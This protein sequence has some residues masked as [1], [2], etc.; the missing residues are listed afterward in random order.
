MTMLGRVR[1]LGALVAA[2][3]AVGCLGGGPRGTW[4]TVSEDA[5][6]DAPRAEV[7]APPPDAPVT[8]DAAPPPKDVA[9][10]DA[11]A[12]VPVPLDGP[13]SDVAP[14]DRCGATD[15]GSAVGAGVARGSTAGRAT[16][17]D[18]AGCGQEMG[19]PRG[20]T[21]APEAVF[22]WVAPVSGR[23]TFDTAGSSYDTLLYVRL[24]ACDG[25]DL[26][27][28]DDVNATGGDTS[29]RVSF[30]LTRGEAVSIVVDGYGANAGD[31]VLNIASDT[32]VPP[33]AGPVCSTGM[34]LCA[35]R[36]VDT[37]SDVA[38]CGGCGVAC[39]GGARCASGRCEAPRPLRWTVFVYGH[40][41]HNLS[42]S[43][44]ADLEEMASSSLRGAVQLVVLSDWNGGG[45]V[46]SSE[47]LS[48]WSTFMPA[49]TLGAGNRWPTGT[50][51]LR[52]PGDRQRIEL[53]RR[54]VER[55]LDDP[56]V[57]STA[58]TEA[59]TRYPADRYGVILWDHGGSWEG[60]FG[61]D[62]GDGTVAAPTGMSGD[63]VATALREG[64]RRAGLTAERPFE[65]VAFDTCLMATAEV[66]HAFRDVARVYM[67]EAELDFG[68]G[69]DYVPTLTW[70]ASN[71]G[72]AVQ[73]FAR[74]EMRTWGL[75]H[76]GA[77]ASDALFRSKVALDLAQLDAFEGA[78]RSFSDQLL[79]GGMMSTE[80][81]A[82]EFY[83]ARPTY[84]AN[85]GG[86]NNPSNGDLRDLGQI[87]RGVASSSFA[88][89]ALRTSARGASD[90][91]ARMVIASDAGTYRSM[92]G[93]TGLHVAA[94]TGVQYGAP[95]ESL[96]RRSASGW[97][98]ATRW[99]EV[100]AATRPGASFGP[101]IT[102][103]LVNGVAPTADRL[104]RVDFFARG[105]V[106]EAEVHL[107]R[108]DPSFVGTGGRWIA[109]GPVMQSIIEADR[110]YSASWGGR[111]FALTTG[112][113][114]PQPVTVAWYLKAFEPSTRA[115]AGMMS[116]PGICRD[117][118]GALVCDLVF[119]TDTLEV[120]L[121][122][123]R[124]NGRPSSQSLAEFVRHY[125]AVT[126]I[127][128]VVTEDNAGRF[129]TLLNGTPVSLAAAPVRVTG[130]AAPAGLYELRTNVFDVYGRD[131]FAQDFVDVRAPFAR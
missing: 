50:F 103:T 122:V 126:F 130:V 64:A 62:G 74:E 60:G 2:M 94:P 80:A 32:V 99:T 128:L 1:A 11:A 110:P 113:S 52:V 42:P 10:P 58:V 121:V 108:S 69:W 37:A 68:N 100:L 30:T 65:F 85:D 83:V 87:L 56:S 78:V 27:C 7:V 125:G 28:N 70:L 97:A 117:A 45:A 53:I 12:D 22:R 107:T 3:A 34:T 114:A 81:L 102:R 55:N 111:L 106:V 36:C 51:W 109:Y 35:G 95:Y 73:D 118:Y 9:V 84:G 123:T 23:F 31:F 129:L 104:P 77:T 124:S 6:T 41:D 4:G 19:A 66:A 33:D 49:G 59:I 16:A 26:G 21:R 25:P 15:L 24:G 39:S 8:E 90:A 120:D 13:P 115:G 72:A 44:L 43:L 79:A 89:P 38:H 17:L 67:A 82:R 75:H 54:D 88:A 105:A 29:S 119:R 93:Q 116:I 91:L 18:T 86:D 47:T 131:S 5:A 57:L 20:G 96:Y 98:T 46:T 61:G 40:A 71:P 76:R 48:R 14:P 92:Y 112:T 101:V 63:A 127:P